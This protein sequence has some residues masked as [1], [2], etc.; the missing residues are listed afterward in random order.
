MNAQLE[1]VREQV[2]LLELVGRDVTLRR[3]GARYRGLCPFHY[4]KTASFF[5]NPQSKTWRCYGC[6]RSGDAF[7]WL[8]AREGLTFHQA[9]AALE[10]ELIVP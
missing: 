8:M 1:A 10:R 7:D 6:R 5:V 3:A 2:D 4:E 9:V